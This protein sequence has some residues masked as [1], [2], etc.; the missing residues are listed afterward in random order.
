MILSI[1]VVFKSQ[2]LSQVSAAV[3]NSGRQAERLNDRPLQ[4]LTTRF[5]Y[6]FFKRSKILTVKLTGFT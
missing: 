3:Q 5:F 2:V 6:R 4:S 1:R